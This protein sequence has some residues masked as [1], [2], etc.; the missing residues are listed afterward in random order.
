MKIKDRSWKRILVIGTRTGPCVHIIST[1]IL[2]ILVISVL[3]FWNGLLKMTMHA[4]E[5]EK[6][7]YY[8]EELIMIYSLI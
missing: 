5:G 7:G 6:K 4:N 8:Y 3:F 1:D 2:H